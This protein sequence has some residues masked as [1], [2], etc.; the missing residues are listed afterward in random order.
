MEN[1]STFHFHKK[2]LFYVKVTNCKSITILKVDLHTVTCGKKECS[3]IDV[4]GERS[5]RDRTRLRTFRGRLVEVE[6][7]AVEV[8]EHVVLEDLLVAVQR[9]LLTAHGA[10][11]PVALHMLL[12]L[13]LVI[14]GGEDD[15]TQRTALVDVHAAEWK[16]GRGG[17][18]GE[19]DRREEKD[20]ENGKE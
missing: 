5:W 20:G 19:E 12:E 17:G 13:T 10:D 4:R 11:L 9:E 6:H 7:V 3:G 2:R 8:G 16:E 14:V 15:V 1:R 18:G